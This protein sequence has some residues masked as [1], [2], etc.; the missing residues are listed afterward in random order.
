MEE[1]RIFP[2][3]MVTQFF[4]IYNFTLHKFESFTFNTY[5]DAVEYC[6]FHNLKIA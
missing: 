5:A 1:V 4:K 6:R 3:G 2:A